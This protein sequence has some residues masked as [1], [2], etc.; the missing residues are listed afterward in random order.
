MTRVKKKHEALWDELLK[1]DTAPQ[2]ILGAHG[3]LRPLT[4]RVIARARE[5][6]LTEPL[7]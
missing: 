1:D 5:A 2:D 7:G 6:E 3:L 4:T